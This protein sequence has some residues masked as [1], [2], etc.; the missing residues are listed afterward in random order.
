MIQIEAIQNT[1]IKHH[2]TNLATSLTCITFP[3]TTELMISGLTLP[4]CRAPCA[5]TTAMSTQELFFNLPPYVPNAVL[6]AATM[7]TPIN[8][9]NLQMYIWISYKY[10][11]SNKRR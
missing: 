9:E 8:L 10:C 2:L 3:K 4:A 1:V 7:K 6:L 5:A 11:R